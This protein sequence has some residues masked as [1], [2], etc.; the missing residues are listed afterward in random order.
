MKFRFNMCDS[1]DQRYTIYLC[2][3]EVS[4]DEQNIHFVR[5]DS[6]QI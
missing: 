4:N 1:V 3:S 2:R 5:V 6:M